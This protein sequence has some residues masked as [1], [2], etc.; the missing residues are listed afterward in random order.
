MGDTNMLVLRII[1]YHN[2]LSGI[3]TCKHPHIEYK[4]HSDMGQSEGHVQDVQD[5][6]RDGDC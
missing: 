4:Y 5:W 1:E 2:D 3:E 6:N